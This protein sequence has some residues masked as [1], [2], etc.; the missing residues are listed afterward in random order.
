VVVTPASGSLL[1]R[2]A[3]IPDPR[4]RQGRRHSLAA[5]LAAIVCGILSGARGYKAIAQWARA[6]HA[7][8]GP[9]LGF[10]RRP[11]CAN[12]FRNLLLALDPQILEA[13]LRQ[14]IEGVLGQPLADSLPGVSIDGKTLCNTL[15]TH[16]RNVHLLSL[17]DQTMGGVLGQQAVDPSTNEAKAAFDLLKA[18]VLE[19]RLI[20]GDAMFCQ[21]D[22]CR[23][24]IAGKGD[25]L[26]IVKD[27]QPELKAAIEAEFQ[28][29]F[30]P[31]QRASATAVA[32]S[33]PHRLQGSWPH[34]RAAS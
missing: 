28:P 33:S 9:W 22:L 2:L 5:M 20:T 7:T 4:G 31:H 24:I 18:V 12:S 3:Q 6:Q 8:I 17:F 34:R 16:E 11:P 30:S 21:R 27:N 10:Q 13:V 32:L 14:W 19:G 25:Y 1:S 15:A 26:L 23:E 29:G